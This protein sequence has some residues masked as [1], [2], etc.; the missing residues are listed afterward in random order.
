MQAD[1]DAAWCHLRSDP[2]H[3]TITPVLSLRRKEIELQVVV[4]TAPACTLFSAW[5]GNAGLTS[6][7]SLSVLERNGEVCVGFGYH[8][9]AY[10][11]L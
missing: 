9:L 2:V 4:C 7:R 11:P 6:R 1:A 3:E 10:C 5:V 8:Y